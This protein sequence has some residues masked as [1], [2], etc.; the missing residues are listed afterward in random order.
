MNFLGIG[1]GELILIMVIAV[2][3][4]GP[5]KLVEFATKLGLLIAKLRYMTSDATREFRDALAIDEVKDA[6]EGVKADLDDVKH[7]VE[8]TAHEVADIKTEAAVA[9]SELVT[10]AS[11]ET[12][13][14]QSAPKPAEPER[15]PQAVIDLLGAPTRTAD[16]NAL[17]EAEVADPEAEVI[18]LDET[19]AIEKDEDYAPIDLGET[20][21][22]IDDASGAED[23]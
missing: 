2:L 16:G 10:I 6:L 7:E 4:V 17:A 13:A 8:G 18:E 12:H 1:T 3:V 19:R 22:V 20:R 9:T 11:G 5:E 14:P 21:A 23:A 15:I